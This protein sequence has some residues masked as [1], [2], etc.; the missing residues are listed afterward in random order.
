MDEAPAWQTSQRAIAWLSADERARAD[1]FHF[2]ADR[3]RFLT[4]HAGM[5]RLLGGCLGVDPG[6]VRFDYSALGKPALAGAVAGRLSCNLSHS[7]TTA[8]L[9][10]IAGDR[11]LGV[12]VE[13]PRVVTQAGPIADRHFT[14]REAAGLHSLEGD[15][16]G[17]RFLDLWTGKE[18]IVKLLGSGLHF[19][20]TAFETPEASAATG[21]VVL[22]PDN[23]LAL[24]SCWL[25]R[26]PKVGDCPAAA[27]LADK[28]ERVVCRRLALADVLAR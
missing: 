21:E 18:A 10:I 2:Q 7:K 16:H 3:R 9:A 6:G 20:L 8:V 12:D 17:Q 27:A 11:P 5:R 28:P 23:P 25:Q 15:A 13:S 4:A 19:P 24:P 26:L 14:V 1:R 22:P